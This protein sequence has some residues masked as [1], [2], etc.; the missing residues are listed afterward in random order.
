MN[1][2]VIGSRDVAGAAGGQEDV[3]QESQGAKTFHQ[4]LHLTSLGSDSGRPECRIQQR[5]E[6][7]GF[8]KS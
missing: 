3:G 4:V 5:L 6:R 7:T 1:G 8:C 2:G